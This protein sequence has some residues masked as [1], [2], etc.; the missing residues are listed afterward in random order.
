MPPES[1]G[2]TF[3]QA[4]AFIWRNTVFPF[5]IC[6]VLVQWIWIFQ[7]LSFVGMRAGCHGCSIKLQ[8]STRCPTHR[9]VTVLQQHNISLD[10]FDSVISLDLW[11][12]VEHLMKYCCFMPQPWVLATVSLGAV[13]D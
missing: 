2:G 9:C 3:I 7:K 12:H 11:P 8:Y 13:V 5:M 10:S 1:A 4:G 6:A